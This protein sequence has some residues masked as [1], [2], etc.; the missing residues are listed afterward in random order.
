MT[1]LERAIPPLIRVNG[2]DEPLSART[3]AGLL[4]EKKLACDA[5]GVAIAHNGRVIPRAAWPNTALAAGDIVE[6][7][8]AKQ[9]G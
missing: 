4:A 6:I 1:E 7:V 9:G 8:R 3:L 2:R 5:R